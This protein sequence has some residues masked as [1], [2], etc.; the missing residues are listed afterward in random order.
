MGLIGAG[1]DVI[2]DGGGDEF[3]EGVAGE[4]GGWVSNDA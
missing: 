3:Y 4:V 1:D 2:V